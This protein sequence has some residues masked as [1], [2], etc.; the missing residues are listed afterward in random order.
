MD[1][2]KILLIDDEVDFGKIAKMNLQLLDHSYEIELAVNGKEGLKKAQRFQPHLILL[3]VLM[4]HMDGF[5]VLKR[6]K[7]DESTSSI[8]VVMLT[9]KTDDDSRMK[10]SS[11]YNEEYLTKPIEAP[12]LR[13]K[14]EKV[15]N[16]TRMPGA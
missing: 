10:A 14:I 15:L 1:K 8:P 4:P 12:D 3:D 7:E 9:A 5:E 6:L 13:D 16:R 11:L 2:K